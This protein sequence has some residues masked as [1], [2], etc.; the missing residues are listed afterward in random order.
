MCSEL[1]A[2]NRAAASFCLFILHFC[3]L[4]T[5]CTL[6]SK[7]GTCTQRLLEQAPV[8]DSSCLPVHTPTPNHTRTKH[9]LQSV[10]AMF[11]GHAADVLDGCWYIAGGGNNASGCTD[12][13]ALDLSPLGSGAPH[14][15]TPLRWHT[16]T[17]APLRDPV[18]SEGLSLLAAPSGGCLVAFGGYNGKYHN[19]VSLFRPAGG[20][21]ERITALLMSCAW[22]SASLKSSF[23]V[24]VSSQHAGASIWRWFLCQVQFDVLK[25]HRQVMFLAQALELCI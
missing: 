9:S 11:T 2:L 12:L 15:N 23:V 6:I 10:T 7:L 24:L 1:R 14:L 16:I 20:P 19:A 22:L 17:E 25:G 13:I 18:A 21:R 4:N 3:M 5:H 8:G